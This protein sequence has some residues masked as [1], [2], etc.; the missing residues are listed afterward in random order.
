M[1]NN[2]LAAGDYCIEQFKKIIDNGYVV[3]FNQALDARLMTDEHARLMSQMKWIHSRIRFGCDTKPQIA[4]CQKAIDLLMSYGYKGEFFLYTMIGGKSDLYESYS[5]IH[6][7]WE[8]TQTF[9]KTKE[10]TSIYAFGQP[11]RNPD[12]PNQKIP[13]WQKDLARWCSNKILFDSCDFKDFE[14]RKGF[15]CIE[16]FK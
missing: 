9:R 15:K 14:P 7:W 5:R 1:D 8:K 6:Y 3:D 4:E 10:G 16:Y 11:Y 12:N 2:I 13:Q